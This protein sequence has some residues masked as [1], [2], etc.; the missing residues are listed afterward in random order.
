MKKGFITMASILYMASVAFILFHI[1]RL[2][3]NGWYL[4]RHVRVV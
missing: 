2:N 4:T 3:M 1:Y